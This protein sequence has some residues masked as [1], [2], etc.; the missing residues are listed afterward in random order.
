MQL[1][2][3]F[4]PSKA[5]CYGLISEGDNG[6]IDTA[7][8]MLVETGGGAWSWVEVMGAGWRQ[9]KMGERFSIT[10]F[11][12]VLHVCACIYVSLCVFVC[13]QM[14]GCTVVCIKRG[15]RTLSF[16][17]ECNLYLKNL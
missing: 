12:H 15:R 8:R 13:A 9:V 11:L 4:I 17:R 2:C 5:Y 10:L 7:E 14:C 1:S 6:K 16:F 3:L